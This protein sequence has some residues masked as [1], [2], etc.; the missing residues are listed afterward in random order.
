MT[1]VEL[2][3][4]PDEVG[5]SI[6]DG[7]EIFW[8]GQPN[9]KSFGY[10]VFGIKYL[11]FYFV[12]CALYAVSQIELSFSLRG[13]F[14]Q[15]L[16]FAI[17]GVGASCMLF[18]LAYVAARHTYYVI[19]AKRVVIRTGI[20]LVFLLNIPLKNVSSIDRQNLT[21]GQGNLSFKVRSKKRIPYLSCWPSVRGTSILEPIPAFRSISDIEEIGNL[22]GRIAEKNRYSDELNVK[23]T[24][25][26]VAA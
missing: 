16:P 8:I 2:S 1:Q 18:L 25:E 23:P 10:H 5:K 6:P 4:L 22:I 11:I 12:L 14:E 24:G 7:E 9:W 21:S 15:Y 3:R 26:G 19:T 13:F 20:A 17:S